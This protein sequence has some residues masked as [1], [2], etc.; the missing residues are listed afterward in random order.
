MLVMI[1]KI[2]V[3][4]IKFV[5]LCSVTTCVRITQDFVVLTSWS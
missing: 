2:I 3:K 5:D 1:F 4:K